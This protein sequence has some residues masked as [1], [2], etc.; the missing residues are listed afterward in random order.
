MCLVLFS[1]T[2]K[3]FHSYNSLNTFHI[4]HF[5]LT[6]HAQTKPHLLTPEIKYAFHHKFRQRAA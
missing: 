4:S 2:I 5:P 1:L 6:I 3:I